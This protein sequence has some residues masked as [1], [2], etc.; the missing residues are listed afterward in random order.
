MEAILD[1]QQITAFAKTN[2]TA[3]ILAVVAAALVAALILK[4]AGRKHPKKLSETERRFRNVFAMMTED[5][6][7]SLISYYARKHNCGREQAM[8]RA[9]EDRARDE[10]RW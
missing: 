2:L 4:V 10:G 1:L 8:K 9:V 3:I 6:R 7:E 5:R